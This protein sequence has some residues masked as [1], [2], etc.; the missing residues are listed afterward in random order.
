MRAP[1]Q[2]AALIVAATLLTAATVVGCYSTPSLDGWYRCDD[3][4]QCAAGMSCDD[5]VCCSLSG[6]P[7]CP[8]LPLDSGVC[9]DGGHPVTYH[10]DQDHDGYGSMDDAMTAQLCAQPVL[11]SWTATPGDCNDSPGVGETVHPGAPELCDGLDND[12]NKLIDDGLGGTLIYYADFDNDGS[13]D[14]N[15]QQAFC[16]PPASGWVTSA[17]DCDPTNG[18]I[19]PG[20]T[21]VCNN[22]DDDCDGVRDDNIPSST[23]TV[24]GRQGACAVG[25]SSC[26][27]GSTVCTQTVNPTDEVCFNTVDEDCDGRLDNQPGCGG[28]FDLLNSAAATV[29]AWRTTAAL[30]PAFTSCVSTSGLT[31]ESWVGQTTWSGDNATTHI[32]TIDHPGAGGWDLSRATGLFIDFQLSM[33]RQNTTTPWVQ[34]GQ[35]IVL[36]CSAST[37]AATRIRYDLSGQSVPWMTASGSYTDT[38]PM[39]SS[40]N[41]LVAQSSTL[42]DINRVEIIIQP[43][44]SSAGSPHFDITFGGLG[45]VAP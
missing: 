18:A 43:S 5:G 17:S 26:S 23:C 21:E 30:N 38:I 27:G 45:F 1:V 34:F 10:Q 7:M 6:S 33:L 35:P 42:T 4:T 32:L 22:K 15:N 31:A 40:G 8:T 20:A 36:Y 9:P 25:A 24:S 11:G 39:T 37:S 19:H 14:P 2:T 41:W 16:A 28:P 13:G 12:C 29:H 44:S 3:Q